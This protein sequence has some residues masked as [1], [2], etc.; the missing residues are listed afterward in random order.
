MANLLLKM[1][2]RHQLTLLHLQTGQEA[3]ASTAVADRCVHV[4]AVPVADPF[5]WGHK[6]ARVTRVAAALAGTP[7]W[8]MRTRSERVRDRVAALA[9]AGAPDILHIEHTVMG[10]YLDAAPGAASTVVVY[11]PGAAAAL[12]RM[13]AVRGAKR[14]PAMLEAAAWRRFEWTVMA[15]ADAAVVFTEHDRRAVEGPARRGDTL[16]RTVALGARVPDEPLSPTGHEPLGVLF[17][18]NFVHAPNGVGARALVDTI[19]PAVRRTHP[20]ARLTIVG[21]HPPADLAALQDRLTMVTGEVSDLRPYLDGAAVVVAPLW[22]GGG[23]RVKVLEAL[24]AGKATVATPLAAEGLDVVDG[25]HLLVRE[26][27]EAFADAI[28]AL[29][30]DP[31]ARGRLAAAGRAWA[32]ERPG[33]DAVAR[34]VEAVWEE[35]L[36]RRLSVT[37]PAHP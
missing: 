32:V 24:A 9:R 22:T 15:R 26:A 23:M 30:S 28:V 20:E 25:E 6:R 16:V 33:W 1:G 36:A 2:A 17:V 4:E 13:R 8:V 3:G 12:D 14:V 37:S 7:D 19:M 21:P 31:L 27:P 11:E 34:R 5:R 18:G 29:L 10:Q 35:A